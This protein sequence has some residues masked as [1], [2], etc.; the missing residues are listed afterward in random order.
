MIIPE[1]PSS[2]ARIRGETPLVWGGS[3]AARTPPARRAGD[4]GRVRRHLRSWRAR[5]LPTGLTLARK[6]PGMELVVAA[7]KSVAGRV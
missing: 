3:G 5:R 4:R 2:Y 7:Q 6:R 1:R